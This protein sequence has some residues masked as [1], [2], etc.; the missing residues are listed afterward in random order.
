[1]GSKPIGTIYLSVA[2]PNSFLHFANSD[3]RMVRLF[4]TLDVCCDS[5]PGSGR[6]YGGFLLRKGEEGRELETWCGIL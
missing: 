2:R 3:R 6:R 5:N 4:G 1:M